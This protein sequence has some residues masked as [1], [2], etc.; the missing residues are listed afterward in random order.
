MNLKLYYQHRA[1][2]DE[3]LAIIKARRAA[4]IFVNCLKSI[5]KTADPLFEVKARDI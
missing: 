4:G 2:F 3:Q 1:L 5:I